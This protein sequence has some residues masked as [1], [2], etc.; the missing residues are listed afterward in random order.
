MHV[1]APGARLRF[2]EDPVR[3]RVTIASAER[4]KFL[5]VSMVGRWVRAAV[6]RFRRPAQ[7]KG[8]TRAEFEQVARDLELSYPELYRLLT[9]CVVS[10]DVLETRLKK[11]DVSPELMNARSAPE[12]LSAGTQACLPIGPSCC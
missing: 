4:G 3:P 1:K 11:L 10:A 6:S 12:H 7:L 9:G 8:M 2:A 5:R